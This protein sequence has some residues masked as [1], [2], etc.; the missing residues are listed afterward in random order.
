MTAWSHLRREAP[1]LVALA[2]PFA[3][4]AACGLAL[5]ETAR[6]VAL[7]GAGLYAG[8]VVAPHVDPFRRIRWDAKPLPTLRL[9][10]AVLS[11]AAALLTARALFDGDP[12]AAHR[13]GLLAT[14]VLL[15]VVG[16]AMPAL[17]PNLFIGIRL[18][19][20][21][22][23]RRVWAQTHRATGHGL[24]ALALG[25]AALWPLLDA[26]AYQALATTS[27]VVALLASAVYSWVL[28]RRPSV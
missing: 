9:A 6:T 8:L 13:V 16:N 5:P 3:A 15:G 4:S 18:P 10:A 20:T 12:E 2:L 7:S 23:D 22:R 17:P 28:S 14:V 1:A 26:A 11:T 24:V 27:V 21:V 19:W 25:L